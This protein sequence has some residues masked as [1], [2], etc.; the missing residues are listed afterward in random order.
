MPVSNE[1]PIRCYS[2]KVGQVAFTLAIVALLTAGTGPLWAP[3]AQ[4]YFG[5]LPPS[6]VRPSFTHSGN[7]E[8][9]ETLEKSIEALSAEVHTGKTEAPSR[10]SAPSP[11]KCANRMTA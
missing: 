7:K 4:K 8:K 3:Y 5:L 6:S 10:T 1:K 11:R 9:I 2:P